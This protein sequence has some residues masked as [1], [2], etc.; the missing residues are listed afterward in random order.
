MQPGRKIKA[1]MN[2]SKFYARCTALFLT[3]TAQRGKLA[4][5]LE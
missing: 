2:F 1:Y 3:K 4:H 5:S